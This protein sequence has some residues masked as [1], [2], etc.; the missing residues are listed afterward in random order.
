MFDPGVLPEEFPQTRERKTRKPFAPKVQPQD[1]APATEVVM[2]SEPQQESH[3]QDEQATEVFPTSMAE[4]TT[5][6]LEDTK[7]AGEPVA[8]AAMTDSEDIKAE[9]IEVEGEGRLVVIT[10]EPDETEA[11]PEATETTAE[12]DAQSEDSEPAKK[13]VR[14]GKIKKGVAFTEDAHN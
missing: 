7:A 5:H 8:T 12:T 9:I 1:A 13:L 10:V 14:K 3:P 6:A 11:I 2:E 4:A